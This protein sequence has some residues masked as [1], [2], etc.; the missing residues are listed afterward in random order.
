MSQTHGRAKMIKLIYGFLIQKVT[1]RFYEVQVQIVCKIGTRVIIRT[2]NP[3]L[4]RAKTLVEL[5]LEFAE[6]F[7]KNIWVT[8]Y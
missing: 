4:T 5:E 6:S 3:I 7:V 2:R 1:R 8:R